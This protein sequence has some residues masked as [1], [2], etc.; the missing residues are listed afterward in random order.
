MHTINVIKDAVPCQQ[1]NS[2]NDEWYTPS[3]IEMY[4]DIGG[5]YVQSGDCS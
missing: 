2:V 1:G 3:Q 4:W 5:I